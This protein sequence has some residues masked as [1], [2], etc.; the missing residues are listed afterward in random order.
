MD[1]ATWRKNRTAEVKAPSGTVY[2]VRL[3]DPLTLIQE[4]INAG[5]EKPLD[6]KD[7]GAKVAQP[8]VIAALLLKFVTE[9]KVTPEPSENSLGIEEL[10]S[11]QTDVVALYRK[12]ISPFVDHA[13]ETAEFFRSLGLSVEDRTNSAKLPQTA[14]RNLRVKDQRSDGKTGVERSGDIESAGISSSSK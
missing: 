9:P 7:L 10:M 12:I 13:E 8:K 4:W 6:Q 11:D 2:K 3:L 14:D 1:A 5:V